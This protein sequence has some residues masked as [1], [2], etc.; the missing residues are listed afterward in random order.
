MASGH[1]WLVV[2]AVIASLIGVYFYFKVII[3]MFY[4]ESLAPEKFIIT[5]YQSALLVIFSLLT[6][7]IGLAPGFFT[8][9]I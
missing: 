5:P 1:S 7:L 2:L 9:W 4:K 6:L 8:G 3:A